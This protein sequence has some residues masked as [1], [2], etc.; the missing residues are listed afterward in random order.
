MFALGSLAPE[1][2]LAIFGSFQ[3]LMVPLKISASV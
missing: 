2:S 3:V 1:L